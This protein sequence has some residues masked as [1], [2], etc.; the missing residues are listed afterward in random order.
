MINAIIV[1]DEPLS[2]ENLKYLLKIV[3]PN[4]NVISTATDPELAVSIINKLKPDVLFLDIEMPYLNGFQLYSKINNSKIH[5]IF[6]TAFDHYAI[7]AF[8]INAIDYLL[9]PIDIDL[10]EKTIDRLATRLTAM[11]QAELVNFL[12]DSLQNKLVDKRIVV[13]TLDGVK[14]VT[15]EEIMYLSSENS[16]T[17][18]HLNGQNKFLASKKI[19]DFEAI[20]PDNFVRIHNQHIVNINYID[21]YIKGRSGKIVLKNEV[22]LDVSQ[23]KKNEFMNIPFFK[24]KI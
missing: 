18:F 14:F 5:V 10:L 21:R 22:V 12:E 4:V 9:K 7:E 11:K 15:Q 3:S 17:M 16:Y 24:P 13:N 19:A 6:V 1:D 20:L 23:R 2:I 8:R